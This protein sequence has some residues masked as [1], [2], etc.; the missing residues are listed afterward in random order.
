MIYLAR[1]QKKSPMLTP[2]IH[3]SVEL[4]AAPS[5]VHQQLTEH[6]NSQLITNVDHLQHS[7]HFLST[8]LKLTPCRISLPMQTLLMATLLMGTTTNQSF[9]MISA[10]IISSP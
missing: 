1:R 2:N 3:V 8:C 9:I 6:I 4:P 10:A 7:L 5:D